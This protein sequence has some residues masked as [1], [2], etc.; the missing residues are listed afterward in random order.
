VLVVND[1]PVRF[2][3]QVGWAG[4]LPF[5]EQQQLDD[6]CAALQGQGQGQGRTPGGANQLSRAGQISL[7]T[8]YDAV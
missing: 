4:A 7:A 6:I 1:P 3:E 2:I 8:S 5:L